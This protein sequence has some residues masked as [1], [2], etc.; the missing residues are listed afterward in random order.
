VLEERGA[1]EYTI[2]VAA[3]PPPIQTD[4]NAPTLVAASVSS[5]ATAQRHALCIYDDL[6]N[7]LPPIAEI[8]ATA[9]PSPGASFSRRR[10]ILTVARRKGRET[11]GREGRLVDRSAVH[12]TQAVATSRLISR[13]T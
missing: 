1:M 12:G 5:P 6:S 10:F 2:V 8:F 3:N 11:V 9:A 7:T 13:P 4:V